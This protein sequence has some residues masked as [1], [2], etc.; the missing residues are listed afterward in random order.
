MAELRRRIRR[1]PC[2]GCPDREE[3]ARYAERYRRLA[4]ETEAL[5]RRMAGRS[6]VIARTFDRVC[7][8]LERLG[9]LAGDT[10]T[11]GRA[12]AGPPVHRA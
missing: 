3:H 4:R 7:R 9:Y 8:V 2:H 5:E 1:H 12:A 10:V 6:H 11:A